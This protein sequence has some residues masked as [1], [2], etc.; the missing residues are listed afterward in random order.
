MLLREW[1][2][3]FIPLCDLEQVPQLPYPSQLGNVFVVCV[4]ACVRVCIGVWGDVT[5]Y[6]MLWLKQAPWGKEGLFLSC[7]CLCLCVLVTQSC[8]TLFDPMDYN[9][10]GSSV[11]GIFQARIQE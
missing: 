9:P 11:C 10:P 8:L 5:I 1:L 3:L 7:V 2:D 4:C 6:Q